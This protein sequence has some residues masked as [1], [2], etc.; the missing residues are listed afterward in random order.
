M[1]SRQAFTLTEVLLALGIISLLTGLTIPAVQAAREASRDLSCR[2]KL[3]QCVL[4][5]HLHESVH[6]ALPANVLGGWPG[7]A[8]AEY[9]FDRG[10]LSQLLPYIEQTTAADRWN[11]STYSFDGENGEITSE[12]IALFLCPSSPWD[13]RFPFV[14]TRINGPISGKG[15][16]PSDFAVN[17]GVVEYIGGSPKL[18]RD[19]AIRT[20]LLR[21]GFE[22]GRSFSDIRDGTSNT[23]LLWE[24]VGGLKVVR[25]D[26]GRVLSL[27]WYDSFSA[28]YAIGPILD[29]DIRRTIRL[30]T[31]A[32]Y[33]GYI[34]AW[35]GFRP[36]TLHVRQSSFGISSSKV[37]GTN[38]LG[39]PFGFHPHHA[40]FGFVD[41]SVRPIA[42]STDASV[43]SSLATIAETD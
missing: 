12:P 26:V 7:M 43:L 6:G 38:D 20:V 13:D 39:Q 4:A 29:G 40:N 24:S 21:G 10:A 17:A 34:Q 5:N 3:R 18:H 42:S 28:G 15:A 2:N 19:G 23:V 31:A 11:P 25:D 22:K 30:E 16:F 8:M 36:G 27:S 32:T 35:A 41:G 14:S 1:R 33:V 9:R 37:N